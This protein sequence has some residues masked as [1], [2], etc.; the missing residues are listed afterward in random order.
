MYYTP[1]GFFQHASQYS[2]LRRSVDGHTW[3]D[4][5]VVLPG[6]MGGLVQPTIV[7]T[8]PHGSLRCFFRSR[9]ADYIFTSESTDDGHNW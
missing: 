3:A 4:E 9:A 8:P 6:T 7:R 1:E 2:S 5:E